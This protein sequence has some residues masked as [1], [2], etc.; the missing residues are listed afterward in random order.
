MVYRRTG[1]VL[2]DS[3]KE[4]ISY[5]E[6]TISAKEKTAAVVDTNTNAHHAIGSASNPNKLTFCSANNK[7]NFETMKRNEK[8]KLKFS[9]MQGME[10]S[11]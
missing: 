2:L 4:L 8:N 10:P 11:L 3:F 6:L 5:C 9:E 7:P 1:S